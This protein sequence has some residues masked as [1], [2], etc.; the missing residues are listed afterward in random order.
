MPK[1]ITVYGASGQQGGAVV[2]AIKRHPTLSKLYHVR[3]VTRDRS[4]PNLRRDIDWIEADL[5]DPESV[6]AATTGSDAVFASTNF[7]ESMSL[8]TEI[9]Q[10]KNVAD[11]AKSSNVRHLIWSSLPPIAKI[12]A[13]SIK[14]ALHFDSKAQVQQYIEAIKHDSFASTHIMPGVFMQNFQ[15]LITNSNGQNRLMAYPWDERQTRIPLIDATIDIGTYVVAILSLGLSSPTTV[16]GQSFQAVSEWLDPRQMVE[17]LSRVTGQPYR[18]SEV[19]LEQ[20]KAFMPLA[21]ADELVDTVRLVREYE[22]YGQGAEGRQAEDDRQL[23]LH[24][25]DKFTWEEYVR[26]LEL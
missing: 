3:G 12:S 22:Y 10:G 14:H 7:W 13:G 15:G 2:E 5:N 25:S 24:A 11:A 4:Q 23:G 6:C 16:D 26:K 8:S 17:T 20:F 18:Y 19:S 9:Q 21:M 1:T